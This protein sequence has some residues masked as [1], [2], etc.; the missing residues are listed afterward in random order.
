M[1][2][3]Q[4]D[5]EARIQ[6]AITA[7]NNHDVPSVRQAAT[8]FDVPRSTLQDRFAGRRQANKTSKQHMQRLTVQ[9]EDSVVKAVY[10]L[11]AWGWPMSISAIEHLASQLL[12]AKGDTKPLGKCWY[13]N[14]LA[15][16]DEL[17]ARRS[18]ALD[19][20]RKDAIDHQTL[21]QWFNLFQTTRLK[22]DVADDDIYNIDEKGCMKG[23]GDNCKVIVPR[24]KKKPS[25]IQ[26]GNREWVSIIECISANN[27]LLP[28]FIIFE[29]SHIQEAWIPDSLD[30]DVVIQVSPN[31]W[32]N[33]NIALD[34]IRHFNKHTAGRTRGKYRLL[35]LDGHA[36]HVSPQFVEYCVDND[37]V[38][39]CLPPH[40]THE[41]QPLDVGV[42]GPLA[43]EY[44][45]MVSQTALFGA[46][47]INNHQFLVIYLRVRKTAIPRNIASGWRGAGLVPF[48]LAKVLERH[49]EQPS[50]F[51]QP[52]SRPT[53]T[54][55][56]TLT[57]HYGR[58]ADIA[59][60]DE[61]A[62]QINTVVE[63]L[64]KVCDTPLRKRVALMKDSILSLQAN[65]QC[66]QADNTTLNLL[67]QELIKKRLEC[68][69]KSTRKHCGEARVL[70]VEAI[71]KQR[72]EREEKQDQEARA[73][74]RRLALRGVVGFAKT[75]WKE[76]PVEYS[77]FDET[78]R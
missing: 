6:A 63:D 16:H 37:I 41:L 50:P 40:S 38:P 26:P 68:R 7:L 43:H 64:F 72:R 75:V 71:R 56:V 46:T 34:W 11:D 5:Q 57:D 52:P 42:F 1:A 14:F 61:L 3:V 2:N 59:V 9:E 12:L 78:P 8:L 67:N 33:C 48:N 15:R 74:A 69:K 55:T 53:V 49:K 4:D 27:Y 20:S 51:E 29:G 44:R 25:S 17:K 36:S 18:R 76:M 22:Y 39:L 31:G 47:R 21:E 19:Q 60:T 62:S 28:P 13:W 70:T 54:P 24:S 45:K 73:K 65:Q 30:D 10:Q 23:I 32:T 35:I 77:Y 58:R 66:L